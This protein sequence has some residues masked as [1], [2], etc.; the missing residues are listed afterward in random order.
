VKGLSEG[1]A[2]I[3]SA[4]FLEDS[5]W[6]RVQDVFVTESNG[7]GGV[8]RIDSHPSWGDPFVVEWNALYDNAAGK[9]VPK[10]GPEDFVQDLELFR[11]MARLMREPNA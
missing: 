2:R 4:V 5:P 3:S 1:C 11:E 10:T 8:E 9:G 7:R 6:L